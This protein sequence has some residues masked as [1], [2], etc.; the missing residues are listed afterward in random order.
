MNLSGRSAEHL[1]FHANST[2]DFHYPDQ[3]TV[4]FRLEKFTLAELEKNVNH[5]LLNDELAKKIFTLPFFRKLRRRKQ[6][7]IASA[8][9]SKS[10]HPKRRKLRK[11][12]RVLQRDRG[13]KRPF[14]KFA[15]M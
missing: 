15:F 14:S 3:Q 2:Y 9:A 12:A 10:A 6:K 5:A 1:K 8:S 13:V 11:N 7:N 4:R